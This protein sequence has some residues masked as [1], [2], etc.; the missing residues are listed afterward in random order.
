MFHKLRFRNLRIIKLTSMHYNRKYLLHLSII[1]KEWRYFTVLI[2]ADMTDKLNRLPA[3]VTL[4]K[5]L[6][7]NQSCLIRNKAPE[8]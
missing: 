6:Q 1:E 8:L 2:Y 5:S 4:T 3:R 7:I